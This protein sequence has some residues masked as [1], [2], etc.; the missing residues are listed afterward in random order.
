VVNFYG[1]DERLLDNMTGLMY[2]INFMTELVDSMSFDD[3]KVLRPPEMNIEH[4]DRISGLS[5]L[6][7]GIC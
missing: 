4:H 2:G 7:D 3:T 6:H 1:F 5:V